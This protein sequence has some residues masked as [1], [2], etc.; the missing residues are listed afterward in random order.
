MI[1]ASAAVH[2]PKR[3]QAECTTSEDLV[4]TFGNRTQTFGVA[5]P[6]SAL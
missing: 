3:G 4:G 1:G 6:S 5:G 2:R